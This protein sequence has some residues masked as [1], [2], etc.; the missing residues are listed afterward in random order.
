ME[1]LNRAQHLNSE[2]KMFRSYINFKQNQLRQKYE[3][4]KHLEFPACQLARVRIK[5]DIS[6]NPASHDV[7][8]ETIGSGV[9][10]A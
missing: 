7:R 6:H 8:P 5:S 4:D 2:W 3:Q 1:S 10:G 9:A